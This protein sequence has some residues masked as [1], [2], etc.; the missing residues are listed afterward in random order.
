MTMPHLENCRHSE[1]GWCLDC[2]KAQW[3]ELNNLQTMFKDALPSGTMQDG[4]FATA[5]Y[6]LQ[7]L[8]DDPDKILALCPNGELWDVVDLMQRPYDVDNEDLMTGVIARD[9]CPLHAVFQAGRNL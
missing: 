3:T 7:Q 9:K 6:M 5:L 8:Q 1:S 2:V 4:R